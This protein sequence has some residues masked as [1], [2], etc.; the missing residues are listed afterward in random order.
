MSAY[1]THINGGCF[2]FR[3]YGKNYNVHY[4]RVFRE[5]VVF[6]SDSFCI[7]KLIHCAKSLNL[8]ECRFSDK[9][10]R[11]C[12]CVL[13]N[14]NNVLYQLNINRSGNVCVVFNANAYSP[15]NYSDINE[16]EYTVDETRQ[17]VFDLTGHDIYQSPIALS[18]VSALMFSDFLAQNGEY[19]HSNKAIAKQLRESNYVRGGKCLYSDKYLFQ[20]LTSVNV[21]DRKSAYPAEMAR[22]EWVVEEVGCEVFERSIP[23]RKPHTLDI[24]T[25]S[26]LQGVSKYN[27]PFWNDT[28][29]GELTKEI[30][31]GY[32]SMTREEF[33]FL[34]D[35][36]DLSYDIQ[37]TLRYETVKI[38]APKMYSDFLF[39]EKE[40]SSGA[41]KYVVK[42]AVN[43]ISGLLCD[44]CNPISITNGGDVY[45]RGRIALMEN[46]LSS[47]INKFI[48]ADTDSIH[49]FGSVSSGDNLG[50]WSFKGCFDSFYF[51]AKTYALKNNTSFDIKVAGAPKDSLQNIQSIEDFS[52]N[53][54]LKYYLNFFNEES[55][56]IEKKLTIRKISNQAVLKGYVPF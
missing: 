45:A 33:E 13:K 23:K 14:Q 8:F 15:T 11:G 54:T 29:S 6:A 48:Y 39:E 16:L 22:K 52:K 10:K 12:Y 32:I 34:A 38:N 28:K 47:K 7:S 4:D 25:F 56:E 5:P 24:I 1:L 51:G 18:R 31:E 9:P 30:Y 41:R 55:G 26:R 27:F 17:A 36:F 2:L 53:P 3:K 40:K 49:T 44:R 43:M 46:I 21:Y 35:I 50:D 42:C 20:K 37:D 19:I